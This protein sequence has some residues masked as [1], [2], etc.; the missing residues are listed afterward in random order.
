MTTT[1]AVLLALL[2]LPLVV[3]FWLTE[4]KQQKAKRWR[5]TGTTYRVIAE[6]L[7]V[8]QTTARKYALA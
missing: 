3:L 4:S 1:L 6:R 8:S 5:K 7:H 2:F